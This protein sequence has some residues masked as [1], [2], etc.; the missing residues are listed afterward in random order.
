V[1]FINFIKTEMESAVDNR[2]TFMYHIG[3]GI[4]VTAHSDYP[5]VQ[6]RHYFLPEGH[7][8][9]IPT[10]RGIAL[11]L[12]EWMALLRHLEDIK[13]L[14]CELRDVIPCFATHEDVTSELLCQEC[15]PLKLDILPNLA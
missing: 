1:H 12:S 9:P 6:F 11:R 7:Q 3:G 14:A 13:L 2:A 5:L 15:N 10:R 8:H 4:Y